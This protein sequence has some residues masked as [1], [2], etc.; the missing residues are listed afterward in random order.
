MTALRKISNALS[1]AL[2]FLA[3]SLGA[4]PR[5]RS[6]IRNQITRNGECRNV[7]ITQYNGDLMLYGS[8]GY[9]ANGC[10]AGLTAALNELNAKG[11]YIDDVQLTEG[12]KWL[13][14]YG[15]NGFRWSDIPYSLEQKIREWNSM[16]EI[17]S[18]VSFNDYGDWAAVS[19]N[20]VMASDSR[21]QDWIAEGMR[22]YGTVWTTCITNDSMVVVFEEGF[23]FLGDI[24]YTLRRELSNTYINVYRLKIAGDSWFFSDGVSRYRYNM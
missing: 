18:S 7:A 21:I 13:I 3:L 4:Q 23:T 2:L 1:I 5:D 8:N 20:Y 10:P 14:L 19:T 22:K 11:E 16:G 6:F 12:G 24:P 9:A 17:I 15:N